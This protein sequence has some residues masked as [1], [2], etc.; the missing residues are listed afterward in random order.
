MGAHNP[1]RS[2]DMNKPNPIW[3]P[4]PYLK[5][6][7][8]RI[9]PLVS[10]TFMNLI[11]AKLN[12]LC[13]L[14]I[15]GKG[16]ITKADGN[17]VIEIEDQQPETDAVMKARWLKICKD[18]TEYWIKVHCSQLYLIAPGGGVG[19]VVPGEPYGI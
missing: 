13:N 11:I 4:I 16:K 5:K 14:T 10:A 9:H 3:N 18:G 2:R 12:A 6:G 17:V 8:A 15:S 7:S 19:A 1:I